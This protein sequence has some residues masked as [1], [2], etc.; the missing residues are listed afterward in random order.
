MQKL[1]IATNNPSKAREISSALNDLGIEITSLLDLDKSKFADEPDEDGETFEE[2]ARIKAEFWAKESGFPTLADD[3][4]ILVDA[5]PGELGV[6]T[7]RFGAGANASDAEWLDHFLKKM[8]GAASRKAKFVCVLAFAQVNEETEFFEGDVDGRIT[9]KPEAPILPRIPLSSVF[10]ADGA[11]K[12]FAAMEDK[13]RFSHRGKALG[14][15]RVF[16][17]KGL[18]NSKNQKT[19]SR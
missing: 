11:D 2:N 12:V 3:S 18:Q 19:N 7:V 6:K 9:E 14:K 13:A 8:E 5:L 15:V 10:L 1:L 17:Q 16:L 4:G